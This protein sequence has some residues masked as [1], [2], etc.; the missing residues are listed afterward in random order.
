NT[1]SGM[2]SQVLFL[3]DRFAVMSQAGAA[4]TLPFVIQNGQTYIDDAM[5]RDASISNAKIGNVIQSNNW[6]G[7]DVGWMINKAGNATFNNVTVRGTIYGNDGYFNG[8]V[9]ANKIEG[10]V[11]AIWTFPA[12]RVTQGDTVR[13]TL[14][15]RG[16]LNYAARICIPYS[17]ITYSTLRED[18]QFRVKLTINGT[19]LLDDTF[20]T[21]TPQTRNVVGYVDIPAGAVNVPITV[22]VTKVQGGQ[23]GVLMFYT[24][25]FSVIASPAT[26][27][28]F[29]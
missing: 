27:R 16:G 4:V 23:S 10:D 25:N 24:D 28:F 12:I 15:W 19:A 18:N 9:R 13:R 17:S 1:P 6:N 21:N 26:N 20:N 11:C 8:T 5:I 22:E 2:Q 7:S 3:A 14:Y 29:T